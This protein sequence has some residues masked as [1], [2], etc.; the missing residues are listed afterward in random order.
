MDG[1]EI[2]SQTLT[3]ITPFVHSGYVTSETLY[4]QIIVLFL[5]IGIAT[6]FKRVFVGFMQGKRV[7]ATYGDEVAKVMRQVLLISQLGILARDI[8]KARI[9]DEARL[10]DKI[11]ETVEEQ[12]DLHPGAS[13][14]DV[15]SKGSKGTTATNDNPL[16]AGGGPDGYNESFNSSQKMKIIELL[17]AYEDPELENNLGEIEV[18]TP[19][20]LRQRYCDQISSFFL[21]F[22]FFLS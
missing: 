19:F 20:G 5:A 7:F 14:D 1:D 22:F 21:Y 4:T 8:E 15:A 13:D 17:G 2:H 12:F 9:D 3:H 18:R 10:Q 6:S 11:W 16:L